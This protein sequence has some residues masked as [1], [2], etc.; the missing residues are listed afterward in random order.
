MSNQFSMINI[1]RAARAT[2]IHA[3]TFPSLTRMSARIPGGG[4]IANPRCDAN[5][6]LSRSL[7]HAVGAVEFFSESLS[8]SGVRA[9]KVPENLVRAHE[10]PL[11]KLVVVVKWRA[12]KRII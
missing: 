9:R 8:R 2:C 7:R 11:F 6:R 1:P 4:V 5:L 3:I 12:K 10:L